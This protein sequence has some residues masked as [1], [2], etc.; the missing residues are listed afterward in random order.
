MHSRGR[1]GVVAV[2]VVML[3]ATM[4]PPAA[5]AGP[6]GRA[7]A[8]ATRVTLDDP[9]VDPQG[10][11][12]GSHIPDPVTFLPQSPAE[13][14]ANR[15]E[16]VLG[17][18]SR[19]EKPTVGVPDPVATAPKPAAIAPA[20]TPASVPAPPVE[21]GRAD[22]DGASVGDHT[23]PKGAAGSAGTPGALPA[24]ALAAGAQATFHGVVRTAAG[25][26]VANLELYAASAI[27]TD[28]GLAT[29]GADGTYS[30]SVPVGT[31]TLHT[32]GGSTGLAAG[33]WCGAVHLCADET[34]ATPVTL[35]AGESVAIDLT[36]DPLSTIT[37]IIL[38][39]DGAPAAGAYV[40]A[41]PSWTAM[42]TLADGTFS[43]TVQ[44]G[45][46]RVFASIEYGQP[47]GYYLASAP[48]HWAQ[49]ES[50]ATA[51]D[52][53]YGGTVPGLEI[54]LP[55]YRTISGVTRDDGGVAVSPGL[56]L[57]EG[58]TDV[59]YARADAAG[60]FSFLV[61][62]G[63]G[64]TIRGD[65][66][67]PLAN[68]WYA[69]T[70][71]GY[72]PTAD[73]ATVVSAGTGDVSGL[74]FRIPPCPTIEGRITLE[75]GQAAAGAFV[76]ADRPD[77][78]CCD[79]YSTQTAPDGSFSLPVQVRTWTL[80]AWFPGGL[81]PPGYYT[82]GGWVADRASAT[83]LDVSLDGIRGINLMVPR[84]RHVT[85]TLHAP[86]GG[87]AAQVEVR[88]SWTIDQATSAADGSYT[89]VLPPGGFTVSFGEGARTRA[90]WRGAAGYTANQA[91][92]IALSTVAG[93]VAG[94]DLTLPF[95]PRVQGAVADTAGNPLAGVAVTLVPRGMPS[96]WS[97]A[98]ATTTGDGRYTLYV[99]TSLAGTWDVWADRA[100]VFEALVANVT[101]AGTD[102]SDVD[103]RLRALP[104]IEGSLIDT[105]GRPIAGIGITVA[106]RV[107]T[108]DWRDYATTDAAGHY[109]MVL[110]IDRAGGRAT[111]AIAD[112]TAA[113][114]NGWLG[115]S[116]FSKDTPL[117][118]AIAA[119][120]TR[121]DE[122][123]VPTYRTLSGRLLGPDG[124]PVVYAAVSAYTGAT[125]PYATQ[126]ARTSQDG[127]WSIK[128]LP[129]AWYIAIASPSGYT[130]GWLGD[131]G[132]HFSPAPAGAFHLAD[133]DMV[134]DVNLP[135]SLE[136]SGRVTY[137]GKPVAGV[138]VD[139][140][141][142]GSA[143]TSTRT[144][145]D[146]IWR[147][148]VA[149]GAY[150]VGFY[151][152]YS[153]YAQGWIGE[154]GYTMD[155][156]AAKV[157]SVSTAD[158]TGVNIALKKAVLVSG[159]VR[160]TGGTALKDVFVEVFANGTYIAG[161]TTSS[162]GRWMF[163][164]PPASSVQVWIYDWYGRVAPG[165][166][167]STSLTANYASA[168][169]T[170]VG[171]KDVSGIA[172]RAPKPRMISGV[173]NVTNEAGST[174]SL[175]GAS[176]E[177]V[178]YGSSASFATA[179]TGGAFKM[180]VLPGTYR[181]WADTIGLN[182]AVVAPY[183]GGWY[184]SSG[185]TADYARAATITPPSAGS[186]ITVRLSPPSRIGGD[187][188]DVG[189]WPIDGVA[190]VFANGYRYDAVATKNG[191][192][193]ITVPPGT[194]R[195]GFYDPYGTHLEGWYSTTG[196]QADYGD[197]TDVEVAYA[198]YREASV[199]L[200]LDAPPAAPTGVSATPFH[201]SARVTFT[202][203]GT[204]ASRPIIHS[205]VTSHPGNR[206]CTARGTTSCLVTGLTDGT[207]Y[208]FTATSTTNVGS[209]A[210]SAASAPVTPLGVPDAPVAPTVTPSGFTPTVHWITPADNGTAISGYTVTAAP[211]GATCTAAGDAT[212]CTFEALPVGWYRFT[213]VAA[214]AL[215]SGPV[216]APSAPAASDDT[217]PTVSAPATKLRSGVALTGTSLPV[218]ATWTASDATSGLASTT[219]EVDTDGAGYMPVALAA[220]TTV[221]WTGGLEAG[222]THRLRAGATDA[223]GNAA[224]PA[225]GPELVA[226]L[227]QENGSGVRASGTW[228]TA[229]SAAASGGR[230]RYASAK[231]AS[232][233]FT[234]TG[235]SVAWVG[236]KAY[237]N[238][239][240][241]LYLDGK[242]VGTI[243]QHATST[244]NRFVT[245]A[246]TFPTT[247]KHVLKIVVL[248][249]PGTGR[250]DVDAFEVLR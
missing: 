177:A 210:P 123:V 84:Y 188:T 127:S 107:G 209:G 153:R 42:A 99:P 83:V 232:L 36:M 144:W 124:A 56:Q 100:G 221:A 240:A 125:A 103:F 35:G 59:R 23:V 63:A 11:L 115:A 87:P 244:T 165:W 203:P 1:V 193:R 245:W 246:R 216:S 24:A 134:R 184:R 58:S 225:T 90:G 136:M 25:A 131:E 219:L 109:R 60:A 54:T 223:N 174:K 202:E 182:G 71:A 212:S 152:E 5:V 143:Y 241:S 167:T 74:V 79:S 150:I 2:L 76:Q 111:L 213:V 80:H 196:Y 247:G 230:T 17:F 180:P 72:A 102:L 160:T 53:P 19:G 137:G 97:Y 222:H 7:D 183:A 48:G 27:P 157:I 9:G 78:T 224:D 231:G 236:R 66:T 166:R 158:V 171:T 173:A 250:V 199:E 64:Y 70:A 85:G 243:K 218:S 4:A 227:V 239:R 13:R 194:Y 145:T 140:L 33:Y 242:L 40:R 62:S 148:P 191:A 195:V 55:A 82:P 121:T 172:V 170:R 112:P 108:R 12:V 215:G 159:T 186:R 6:S 192:Y 88:P 228:K 220:P 237:A 187:L 22:A 104:V 178:A 149:P 169:V 238:G 65:S 89:L 147:V 32:W 135:P 176:L 211:G 67:C 93:D 114:P 198:D 21:V 118:F 168:A 8:A 122:L 189:G 229:T 161:D 14:R 205:T 31:Y 105:S 46:Y 206:Q 41:T 39:P 77:G 129:G 94:Y 154:T 151:D 91:E 106:T 98:S 249:S 57:V 37:G 86:D 92:A 217:P 197:A 101:L 164:V 44:P 190:V 117:T 248:A 141:L 75:G 45:T 96:T 126:Q 185:V 233:S 214:N 52:I 207:A 20:P 95:R 73:A 28:W 133:E 69:S 162:R 26:P 208:T 113:H 128:L 30:M 142:N 204:S 200:P 226:V 110:P 201:A 156:D 15:P 68:V 61:P 47:G 179:G 130:S 155:P 146:G 16:A 81:Y 38:A 138:E 139:I 132:F 163:Y 49:L 181:V 119:D 120:S 3:A 234:F 235:R 51:F 18:A 10:A 34:D 116:G 175:K 29:T 43:L 50:A